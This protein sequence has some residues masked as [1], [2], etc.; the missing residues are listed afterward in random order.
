VRQQAAQDA[1]ER[2]AKE[3]RE[4]RDRLE[5]QVTALN[6]ITE[7]YTKVLSE[8]L[9]QKAQIA[10]TCLHIK[11][12]IFYYMRAIWSHEDPHQRFF[13]LHKV[14]VPIFVERTATARTYT[15]SGRPERA[16][17]L[18]LPRLILNGNRFEPVAG[19]VHAFEL[20]TELEPGF[21]FAALSEV[22]DLD[23][24]LGCKGNYLIFPMKEWNGLTRFMAAPYVDQGFGLHDPDDFGNWTLEEFANY[25]CC[26][27]TTLEPGEFEKLKDQLKEQYEQLITAPRRNGEEIVVPTGSLFIEALPG[28]HPILEDFKLMHRAI[29]VKKAQAEV[30][31][32]ELENL[33]YA[34]R[35]L[36]GNL[37]DPNIAAKYVFEGDGTA[38]VVAPS[39]S[40]YRSENP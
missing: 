4:T 26:L 22:A 37:D 30:R 38:T 14:R 3:E 5:L 19:H 15:I 17:S 27:K 16:T 40:G 35:I 8:H 33:R 11:D 36:G 28:A 6:S 13:R 7:R 29:D 39:A 21:Q 12:N 2:A 1:Y 10:R 34:A 25:V 20:E 9:N 24:L 32:A 31:Q 18:G 23:N